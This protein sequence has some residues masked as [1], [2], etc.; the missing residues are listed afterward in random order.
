MP[1]FAI[2][3]GACS[4]SSSAFL[5]ATDKSSRE[6]LCWTCL[7]AVSRDHNQEVQSHIGV[8]EDVLYVL[9][10]V[11]KIQRARLMKKEA[12]RSANFDLI[13]AKLN[14][15]S[16]KFRTFYT[17]IIQW[18]AVRVR[19]NIFLPFL[20]IFANIVLFLPFSAKFC[21]L[22]G[23]LAANVSDRRYFR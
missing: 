6:F 4:I 18:A 10:N 16:E 21:L 7:N 1:I 12:R 8:E 5:W 14:A 9:D 15:S 17:I 19:I 22:L 11:A 3:L 20:P 23:V 2:L 13:S